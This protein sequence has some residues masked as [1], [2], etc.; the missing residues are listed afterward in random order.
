MFACNLSNLKNMGEK[1]K[2]GGDINL[3]VFC[4]K[5]RVNN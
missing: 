4:P 2:E 3:L 1:S 5:Y